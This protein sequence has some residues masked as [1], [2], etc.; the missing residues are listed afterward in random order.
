[1]V[2]LSAFSGEMLTVTVCSPGA[3]RMHSNCPQWQLLQK[4]L[5]RLTVVA[6]PATMVDTRVP[7]CTADSRT[8]L[9]S[10]SISKLPYFRTA[11]VEEPKHVAG[12]P[13]RETGTRLLPFQEVR[14]QPLN[15]C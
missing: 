13:E 15:D 10:T 14:N 1:M 9:P 2:R 5:N 4:L 11:D 3:S 7:A 6:S 12:E 8:G